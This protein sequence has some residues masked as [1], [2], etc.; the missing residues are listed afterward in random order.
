MALRLEVLSDQRNIL[1]DARSIVLGVGGGSFG[2]AADNDWVLPDPQRYLSGHHARVHFR[3]G[4]FYLEDTSTNGTFVNGSSQPISRTGPHALADGDVLR[5]GEYE[6]HVSID[7]AEAATSGAPPASTSA[8]G[9]IRVRT[10]MSTSVDRVSPVRIG[11]AAEDIGASLNFEAL[12]HADGS[13]D[14]PVPTDAARSDGTPARLAR[15][16]AAARARLEGQSAAPADVRLWVQAFCRGAGIDVDKLP[17][18][19]DMKLLHLA[20]Q[21]LR[22]MLLGVQDLARARAE[23]HNSHGIEIPAANPDAPALDRLGAED[24][25]LQL[26][27]GHDRRDLDALRVMRAELK[28][29]VAHDAALEQCLPQALATFM[30]HL[31]PGEIQSRF[32]NAGPRNTRASAWDVYV[33]VF[34]SLTQHGST[35]L[36]H[37]FIEALTQA[38][39]ASIRK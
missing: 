9:S 29:A 18:E 8:T 33:D 15:L 13:G 34:R 35:A 4:A 25:L 3:Q 12:I 11:G 5:F 31:A 1:G 26:F 23:F 28:A 27:E 2:R 17:A 38:Y 39:L 21:M 22:E 6:V 20:G 37:L 36:P 14:L 19:G 32:E 7:V 10:G 24:Y 30:T 16:R